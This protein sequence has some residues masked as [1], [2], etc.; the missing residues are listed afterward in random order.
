MTRRKIDNTILIETKPISLR[1]ALHL[2][3]EV[4]LYYKFI[5]LH[6]LEITET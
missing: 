6:F 1:L 2:Q 5:L 3:L 4:K